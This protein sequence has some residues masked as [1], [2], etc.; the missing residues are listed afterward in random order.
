MSEASDSRVVIVT[1]AARGIGRAI[2][3][4]FHRDGAVVVALDVDPVPATDDGRLTGI[5]CD[6]SDSY[7]VDRAVSD[8]VDRL[9]RLDVMV[10]NAGIGGGAPVAELGDELFRRIID[11]NLFGVFACCRAAAR[12]MIPRRSGVIVTIGSVFGQDPPAGSAAYGAAKAGVAALTKSLARELGPHGI[13]VNCVSPGHIETEMYATALKRRA[14][15]S[16][17]TLEEATSRERD[18]IPLGHFGTP[19]DVAKVVAFLASDD[20]A[21]VTGQR[22]N[23]DGGLQPL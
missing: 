11:V 5:A 4:R 23:V 16:G 7:A 1:G 17:I 2:A 10:C 9:G 21:Y 19:A 13:R 12:A 3:E 20:G 18:P 15:A 6:V 14:A 22:I 8:I